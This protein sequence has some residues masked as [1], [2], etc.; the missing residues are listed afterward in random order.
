MLAHSLRDAGTKKKLVVLTTND[1][2]TA[3]AMSELR[4]SSSDPCPRH[5]ADTT[6]GIV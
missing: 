1:T 3:D 2:M 4:V 5:I 6:L